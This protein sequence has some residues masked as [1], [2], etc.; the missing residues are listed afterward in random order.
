[1]VLSIFK[2]SRL[3][4]F[5]DHAARAR[6]FNE[7]LVR[8]MG[9]YFPNNQLIEIRRLPNDLIEELFYGIYYNG[10]IMIIMSVKDRA[11]V[12]DLI[13]LSAIEY[14]ARCQSE[15]YR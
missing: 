6:D 2:K 15:L 7:E 8:T 10:K 3:K 5:I 14:T 1:M 12:H 11:R 13:V 9:V 4:K